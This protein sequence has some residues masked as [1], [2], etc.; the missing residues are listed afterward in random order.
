MTREVVHLDFLLMV[1]NQKVIDG[2]VALRREGSHAARAGRSDRLSP[3]CIKQV[4]SRI[5]ALHICAHA[6]MHLQVHAEE[7]AH[8][9]VTGCQWAAALLVCL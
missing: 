5:H 6:V 9:C 8:C 3:L 4:T 1:L 7:L 2:Q